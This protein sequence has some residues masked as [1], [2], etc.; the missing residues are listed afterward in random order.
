M[1]TGN[2]ELALGVKLASQTCNVN[3]MLQSHK[4]IG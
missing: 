2:M 1:D 3:T 4:I